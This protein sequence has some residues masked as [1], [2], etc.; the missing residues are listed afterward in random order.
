MASVD[1]SPGTCQVVA[2]RSFSYGCDYT[3]KLWWEDA[4]FFLSVALWS[5]RSQGHT[6]RCFICM[7]LH[8]ISELFFSAK[9]L[10][11]VGNGTQQVPTERV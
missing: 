2:N 11:R 4:S 9:V 1:G 10:A 6:R 7:S 5:G 8:T 3:A